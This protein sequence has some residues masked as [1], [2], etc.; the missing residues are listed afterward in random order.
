[1]PDTAEQV[2]VLDLWTVPEEVRDEFMAAV[3]TMFE[4][5]RELPGFIEGQILRGANPSL[6]ATYARIRTAAER[7]AAMIDPEVQAVTRRLGEIAAPKPH[8]YTVAR[9]FTA[10]RHKR[11]EG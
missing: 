11:P 4:R 6:F 8:T 5:I 2:I 10:P 7:D 3:A 9:T 1:M